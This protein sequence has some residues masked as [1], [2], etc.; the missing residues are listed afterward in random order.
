ME[1]YYYQ[2]TSC[3]GE[4]MGIVKEETRCITEVAESWHEFHTL[5]EHE[6]D[7]DNVDDFI[8]WHNENR[9]SQIERIILEI[10]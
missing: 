4:D 8:E 6:L 2:L 7:S 10:V 1:V 3:T 5:E 9:V